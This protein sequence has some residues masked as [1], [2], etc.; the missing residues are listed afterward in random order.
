VSPLCRGPSGS[1]GLGARNRT[2]CTSCLQRRRGRPVESGPPTLLT[3]SERPANR[4]QPA[5]RRVRPPVRDKSGSREAHAQRRSSCL[6]FP[7]LLISGQSSL[8]V[9][10]SQR[11]SSLDSPWAVETGS[12]TAGQPCISTWAAG[13]RPGLITL[14]R[15]RH[16]F[17]SRWDWSLRRWAKALVR[18]FQLRFVPLSGRP[19]PPAVPSTFR[20]RERP[21][22]GGEPPVRLREGIT[23]SDP[24]MAL[25]RDGD[26]RRQEEP[27]GTRHAALVEEPSYSALPSPCGFSLPL[28]DRAPTH[29][30]PSRMAFSHLCLAIS[31]RLVRGDRPVAM[32]SPRRH[33]PRGLLRG[34]G[35]CSR[36]RPARTTASA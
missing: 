9:D 32:P 22:P 27:L 13:H 6:R 7:L 35:R 30:T 25:V 16:G 12:E 19:D 20:R 15:W 10:Q 2:R 24:T 29:G 21:S 5:P 18:R 36:R 28:A 23:S 4:R 14:S 26:S 31:G 17:K 8:R 34:M 33:Y 1:G 11:W 3:G